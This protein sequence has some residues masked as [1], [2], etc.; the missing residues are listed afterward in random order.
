VV[1]TVKREGSVEVASTVKAVKMS[2]DPPDWDWASF[3]WGVLTGGVVTVV[4][5]GVVLY[6][7]WPYIHAGLTVLPIFG[8]LV[9]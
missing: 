7:G 1:I 4:V 6:Y 9:K 2:G 8:E 5:G 3:G